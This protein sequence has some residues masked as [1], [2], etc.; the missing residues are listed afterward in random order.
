M[1]AWGTAKGHRS[2]K[3]ATSLFPL[4]LI[5]DSEVGGIV[6]VLD[7]WDFGAEKRII[8]F[9]H[10]DREI[11]RILE[12]EQEHQHEHDLSTSALGLKTVGVAD[13]GPVMVQDL[14]HAEDDCRNLILERH[15]SRSANDHAEGAGPGVAEA[16]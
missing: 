8:F 5:P 16:E 2:D 11:S 9:R 14:L 13:Q 10:S 7:L 15:V 1:S 3:N 4:A 6:L 12:D